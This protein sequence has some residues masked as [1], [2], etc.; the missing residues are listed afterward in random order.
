M[1]EIK[2]QNTEKLVE[3]IGTLTENTEVGDIDEGAGY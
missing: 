3:G 2:T 1:T